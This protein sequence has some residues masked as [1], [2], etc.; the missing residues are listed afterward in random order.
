MRREID[1]RLAENLQKFDDFYQAC[2]MEVTNI[3]ADGQF[4]T[5]KTKMAKSP[6]KINMK[7][8]A[9]NVHV[10]RAEGIIR[11]VK[12]RVRGVCSMLPFK[13]FPMHLTIEMIYSIILYNMKSQENT[14]SIM[15]DCW[16]VK[17]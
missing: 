15:E 13:F 14:P 9:R 4:K 5:I 2:G 6:H 11:L 8:V 16:Y 10:K 7:I 1:K 3:H 12:E 17:F